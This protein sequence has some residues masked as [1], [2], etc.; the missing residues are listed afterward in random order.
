MKKPD[1]SKL[2]IPFVLLLLIVVS[3]LT[4]CGGSSVIRKTG[5]DRYAHIHRDVSNI[6][7]AKPRYEPRSRYGNPP[8]YQVFGK[9]YYVKASSLG[10]RQRGIASWYGPKFHGKKTSTQEVY[11][12]YKMTAAHKSLPLPTYARVTN[13]QNGRSIVVR[14]NDRGP[15]VGNR[16]IDLSYAAASKL[17]ILRKGT[18]YV[19]VVA[20][21]PY[22]DPYQQ[23]DNKPIL[24]KKAPAPKGIM[25]RPFIDPSRKAATEKVN[26]HASIDAPGGSSSVRSHNLFLQVGAFHDA[27]NAHKLKQRVSALSIGAVSIHKSHKNNRLLYRVRLGPL[28]DVTQL[29]SV[30]ERLQHHGYSS[31]RVIIE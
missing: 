23:Q 10:Y 20:L 17:D 7:D 21:N 24:V 6:P 3:V 22:K 13:L 8:S 2:N 31:T 11:D 29:D 28:S 5:K 16:I 9:T 25:V 30:S 19:E 27:G 14:I 4:A 15:F 26:K 1:F 18:G 12:M